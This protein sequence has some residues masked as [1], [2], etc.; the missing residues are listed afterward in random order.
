MVIYV[1]K[2]LNPSLKFKVEDGQFVAVE[3]N[4]LEGKI[5]VINIYAPNG[6]KERFF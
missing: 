6:A 1:K 2:D 4:T 3:L 5:L